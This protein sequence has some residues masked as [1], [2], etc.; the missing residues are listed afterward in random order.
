MNPTA[1]TTSNNPKA[2]KNQQNPLNNTKFKPWNT[3]LLVKL[4]KKFDELN[5]KGN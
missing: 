5:G 2:R 4:L 3:P 1:N